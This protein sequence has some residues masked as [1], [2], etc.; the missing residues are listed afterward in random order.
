MKKIEENGTAESTENQTAEQTVQTAADDLVDDG[1]PSPAKT[2]RRKKKSLGKQKQ[3]AGGRF[4]PVPGSPHNEKMAEKNRKTW[5]D[6]PDPSDLRI[7]EPMVGV[8]CDLLSH[9]AGDPNAIPADRREILVDAT[10]RFGNCYGFAVGQTPWVA[11]ML[12]F[13]VVVGP[14]V[15]KIIA[16]RRNIHGK[17]SNGQAPPDNR[18]DR[19]GQNQPGENSGA[20]MAN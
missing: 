16:R 8:F 2:E 10:G 9:L 18:D 17:S 5:D 7:I 6:D 19:L 3:D 14:V 11:F 4:Q 13:G 1:V 20:S 12:A 15:P